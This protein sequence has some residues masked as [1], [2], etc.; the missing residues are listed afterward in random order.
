MGRISHTCAVTENSGYGEEPEGREAL[1]TAGQETGATPD[2]AGA[3]LQCVGVGGFEPVLGLADL[4]LHG[5]F[6]LRELKSSRLEMRRG[7]HNKLI[8]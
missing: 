5:P 2:S 6:L 7:L 3:A 1:R 4:L 8:N